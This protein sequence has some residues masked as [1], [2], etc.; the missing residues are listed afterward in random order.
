MMARGPLLLLGVV[1]S[2]VAA[3]SVGGCSGVQPPKFELDRVERSVADGSLAIFIEATNNNDTPLPLRH[4]RYRV[5]LD[6]E[7]L[8]EGE[9]SPEVTV[10]A[11]STVLFSLPA[12]IAGQPGEAIELIGHV[13]YVEPGRLAEI[14]F[15]SDVRQPE[16]PIRLEGEVGR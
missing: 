8:F 10:P 1:C 16:A 9:R 2:G 7:R 15:D 13:T 5:A 12:P 11:F 4:A 6:G 14:L 3:H